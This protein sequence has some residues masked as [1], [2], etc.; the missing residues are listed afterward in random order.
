MKLL[1]YKLNE[2]PYNLNGKR[3]MFPTTHDLFPEYIE[4]IIKYLEGWLKCNNEI[5]I[6]SKPHIECITAICDKLASFK[7]KI[8]FRFTIGSSSD[9]ILKFWEPNAPSFQER[10]NSLMYAF[11]HGFK[12]SVSCEPFLDG[13]IVALVKN[14]LPYITD[15]IWVGKMNHIRERVNTRGWTENDWKF[16]KIVEDSQT[17]DN[18]RKIYEQLK[19]EPK[20]RWKDSIKLVMSL[21]EEKVG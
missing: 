9:K 19:N 17:D 12:T 21:P 14:L 13:D 8:V 15:T 10:F 5:L 3:A 7:G 20:V 1:P 2:K 6:V 16:L 18:I 4:E 11:E